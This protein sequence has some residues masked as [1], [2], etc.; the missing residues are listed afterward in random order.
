MIADV[1]KAL[2]VAVPI[3]LQQSIALRHVQPASSPTSNR[4]SAHGIEEAATIR[5]SEPFALN[6]Y[7]TAP[8]PSVRIANKGNP[9][10][11]PG[12]IP[13]PAFDARDQ[14]LMSAETIAS[15]EPEV[16]TPARERYTPQGT[17]IEQR[18]VR[19]QGADTPLP[20]PPPPIVPQQPITPAQPTPPP[21]R[22][23]RRGLLIAAIVILVL[24]IIGSGTTVLLLSNNN[25]ANASV[26][27]ASFVSS[28]KVNETTNQG[29][30]DEFQ[31]NLHNISAPPSGKSYYAWLMADS[32]QV[33]GAALLLGK[34]SVNNG[35]INFMYPGDAQHTNLLATYSSFLITEE[36]ANTSPV[37]PTPDKTQWK[38]A[39]SIPQ[40]IPTGQKFSLLDHLRHLLT[41]DPDLQHLHTPLPGG[42]AI[43]TY[44]DTQKLAFWANDALN[45]WKTQNF[46]VTHKRVIETLDYLDGSQLVAK[47]VPTGTP[48]MADPLPSQV[49][50]LALQPNQ[51]PPGYLQHD[52]THL[53]GVVDSPGATQ[54]QKTLAAQIDILLSKS[55]VAMIQER[56][57]AIQLANMS[58][59]QLSQSTTQPILQDMF[60]QA[61]EA[62][63]RTPNYLTNPSQA[64]GGIAVVYEDIQKLAMFNVTPYK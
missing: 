62:F 33:E 20:A 47:D 44:R 18:G 38:Y 26:G 12:N 8:T 59:V 27:S 61:N 49:P 5:E 4:P 57:D 24:L 32:S 52:A 28:G 16:N 42:L 14:Q 30:N 53:N 6:D 31:I 60:T 11:S 13:V 41:D 54:A 56:K 37:A 34:L 1:A 3:E 7:K 64:T 21:A 22:K 10:S 23:R 43:W 51:Q 63:T 36:D 17:Q 40:T 55:Q 15:P 2:G 29:A 50:L 46:A 45:N 19:E 25:A 9:T 58:N 48:L 35:T 39:A